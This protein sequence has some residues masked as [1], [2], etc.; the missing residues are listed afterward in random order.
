MKYVSRHNHILLPFLVSKKEQQK[1]K[2]AKVVHETNWDLS[3]DC[4]VFFIY[5]RTYNAKYSSVRE[6]YTCGMSFK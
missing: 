5:R 1:K 2:N 4:T 6:T 3:R